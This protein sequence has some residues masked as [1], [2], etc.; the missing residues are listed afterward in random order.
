MLDRGRVVQRGS[1][2]Q[3][4]NADGLYRRLWHIQHTLQ[5]D[6]GGGDGETVRE[7]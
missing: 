2:E 6:M 1:H 3:L 5:R 4:I 7:Q